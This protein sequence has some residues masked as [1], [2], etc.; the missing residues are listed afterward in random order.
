VTA[1]EWLTC[2]DPKAMV[3]KLRRLVN[4]RDKPNRRKLRL[5]AVACCHR[6]RHLLE[7]PVAVQAVALAEQF[8]D[9]Q[10]SRADMLAASAQVA[11]MH[12]GVWDAYQAVTKAS[13][14]FPTYTFRS[15]Y[16]DGPDYL[17]ACAVWR[18]TL[19]E[20]IKTDPDPPRQEKPNAAANSA[21][22]AE[23]GT[24]ADFLRCIFGNP[25]RPV[26][27]CLAWRTPSVVSLAQAAYEDRELPGSQLVPACL[28]VL[29]DALEEAG[30][31]DQAMLGHLRE[32]GPHV[33]GCWPVD[34]LVAKEK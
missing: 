33:R 21:K 9:G 24:Q 30:C 15:E 19:W 32:P 17:A 31:T 18:S 22:A 10:A 28:A 5:F 11:K 13:S 29:S 4:L 7:Q 8:A 14:K 2:K 27:D 1:T 23:R 3:W 16:V 34:L 25:F 26:P 6:I 20:H 12:S